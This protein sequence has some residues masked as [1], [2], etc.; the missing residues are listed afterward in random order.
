MERTGTQVANLF[1]QMILARI[2]VPEDFAAVA[3]IMVFI[4]IANIFVQSGLGTALIQCKDVTDEDYS[5]VFYT[6][7]AISVLMVIIVFIAAP[8]IAEFYNMPLL[9]KL[10]RW[11]SLII[12]SGPFNTVQQAVLS[13]EMK[14]KNNFFA[15][16]I[17]CVISGI[18]SIICAFN[19]FGIWSIIILNIL[20]N[21][22][23]SIVLWL[24]VDWRPK[25][26]F[27]FNSMKRMFSF[28]WK[29][30]AANLVGTVYDNLRTLII[31]KVYPTNLLAYYNRGDV[32][33]SSLMNGITGSISAVMLPVLS[34]RQDCAEEIKE[35]LKK[36]FQINCFICVPMMFGLAAVGED[37]IIVLFSN[38]W[39]PAGFFL[40]IICLGYALYPMH[41]ANLQ[42]IYA[43]G[44]SDIVLKL[45][46]IKRVV[47]FLLIMA[48]IPFGIYAMTFSIVVM[49]VLSTVINAIPNKNL[50]NYGLFEQI[51]DI[52]IYFF[53]SGLMAIC[54]ILFRMI[55][56]Y[57][58]IINLLLEIVVGIFIYL[59]FSLIFKPYA[60]KYVLG[61]IKKHTK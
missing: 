16:I 56:S 19:G 39:K 20:N 52:W 1:I 61:M 29:L 18:V 23:Y 14:F 43:V 8:F 46:V 47:G 49:S 6:S 3:I 26:M 40:S 11:Q 13:R 32:V 42:A 7:L 53:M 45:E 25:L 21:V 33:S 5:T 37:L 30:L 36:T 44:R 38:V 31:G 10:I 60:F 28:G 35:M 57:N 4:A 54:V 50:L 41:S 12:L 51:K 15:C 2:L 58:V 17:G 24:L 9:V 55:L 22:L 34:Q 48:S 27:S 59:V